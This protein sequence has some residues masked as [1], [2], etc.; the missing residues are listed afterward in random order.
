ARGAGEA[1]RA[2]LGTA[3]AIDKGRL[4]VG[5]NPA[6]PQIGDTRMSWRIARPGPT[7]LIGRQSGADLIEFPTSGEPL[8]LA[9]SGLLSAAELL[10]SPG[11]RAPCRPG[12]C[13][14]S[15]VS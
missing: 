6:Q 1:A 9:R 3:V 10:Q 15:P 8:L 2:R 7:S 11:R 12:S 14:S 5:T 4:Y 13:G